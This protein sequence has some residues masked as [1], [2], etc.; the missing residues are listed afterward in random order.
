MKKKK[1]SALPWPEA[2]EAH[3]HLMRTAPG[4]KGIGTAAR[5][6]VDG[7]D[8]LVVSFLRP[9]GDT[10]APW[11]RI[12][13]QEDGYLTQDH[14]GTS[15]EWRTA[16][17]DNI[18]DFYWNGSHRG[19]SHL[20]MLSIK[21]EETVTGFMKEWRERMHSNRCDAGYYFD[22][23]I[24]AY[25]ADIRKR[26][27]DEKHKRILDK[28]DGRMALFRE[29]PE[30]YPQFVEDRVFRD[31]NYLF[32]SRKEG[33]VYC[34]RCR[35]E[36][37]MSEAL[38]AKGAAGFPRHN[39][40]SRCPGCGM[41]L[42]AK[43]EGMGRGQLL[44]IN[45]GVLVQASGEDVLVRYFRHIRSYMDDYRNPKEES[46][47]LFRTVYTAKT[48]E[49]YEWGIYSHTGQAR[50]RHP[51]K[52]GYYWVPSRFQAPESAEIYNRDFGLLAGTCM[53]Y[54]CMDSFLQNVYRD[55]MK[56]N[57]WIVDSYFNFYRQ[58]PYIEQMLKIGWFG[59][60]KELCTAGGYD[61]E[62]L[63]R[64]F[65]NGR[66]ILETCGITRGQFLLLKEATGD[67]PA[68]K[69]FR[70]LRHASEQGIRL[71][72][73]DLAK[74]REI[75]D[76][77]QEEPYRNY[78]AAMR[79][80]TLD[81]L[82][83]YLEK[84]GI[85]HPQDYFDYLGW[86]GELGYDRKNRGNLYPKDFKRKH[87]AVSREY[88]ES[89]NKAHME[90]LREFDRTLEKLRREAAK[91]GPSKLQAGG[92]FIRLPYRVDELKKEGE[93]LH[94]CVAT[95][96]DRV[97][98]GQTAIFFVRRLEDPDTPYYTL[99]WK[100][101]RIAQCR[102]SHNCDMTPEVRAFTA[103]FEEKMREYE[104]QQQNQKHLEERKAA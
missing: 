7:E 56:Q 5:Q 16:S 44:E 8:T 88:M 94:H 2:T 76:S 40:P 55:Q 65:Q 17:L 72:A 49:D 85:S 90:S 104:K 78:V 41:A 62:K 34:T 46:R 28:I 50:W 92:L 69:D 64:E 52:H 48:V 15:P 59:L 83:G 30:D 101:H 10:A 98:K 79:H 14:S 21:D 95:Y 80:T 1:L 53:R 74:L 35:K 84:Q 39:Q 25:Q 23:Y 93:S 66:T 97:L 24:L 91:G 73:A 100:D 60:V 26:K 38:R 4:L 71:C 13:C 77:G 47:E 96:T 75:Q 54:S 27:L 20:A 37:P 3:R 81:R 42:T 29:L 99:E 63:R 89:K 32:Y 103:L 33:W 11:F 43:S 45:W 22:D 6:E 67:S 57:P 102:G 70:I 82:L 31:H 36:Y 18:V 61:G 58:H 86:L 51:K 9:D 12:F 87:D 19:N 68:S